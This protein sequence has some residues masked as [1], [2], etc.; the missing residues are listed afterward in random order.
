MKKSPAHTGPNLF[1][2][3]LELRALI[4]AT[5]A[6]S[7]QPL[8]RNIA[9][10][11]G[12]PV[13]V[14]PAFMTGDGGTALLRRYLNASGFKSYGWNQGRN[15]G[16]RQAF[17]DNLL[18]QIETVSEQHG[19]ASVS[20]VGWSLGGVYARAAANAKPE[21]VRQVITLGSPFN[22]ATTDSISGGVAKLYEFLNPGGLSDPMLSAADTWRQSP[23]VPST[24]IYSTGDGVA[25]W[26]YCVDEPGYQTENVKVPGSHMGLTHNAAVMYAVAERL[27]QKEGSWAPFNNSWLRRFWYGDA[28]AS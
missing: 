17:L 14:V 11:N 16:I 15:T 12:Q 19:G 7:F 23:P 25:D 22:V 26:H 3:F 4:E 9:K 2:A 28:L 20:L 24:A 13:I 6:A 27:A 21:L 5:A 10:G 8:L 1:S 18:A